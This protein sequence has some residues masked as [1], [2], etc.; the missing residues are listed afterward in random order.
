MTQFVRVPRLARGTLLLPVTAGPLL[1]QGSTPTPTPTEL[2]VKCIENS[3]DAF[4]RCV[5]DL[6]W[7]AEALCYS[8][9][10]ADGILCVPATLLKLL[11]S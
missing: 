8:K 10:G 1:A 4:V 9:Y 2:F 5:A 6:P 11:M 7:Y 3:A